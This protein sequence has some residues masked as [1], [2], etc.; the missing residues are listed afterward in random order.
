MEETRIK[1]FARV[2]PCK[3]RK[4]E[5]AGIFVDQLDEHQLR[6]ELDSG[7]TQPEKNLAYKYD[8]IFWKDCT[9]EEIYAGTARQMIETSVKGINTTIFAYGQTGAGKTYTMSGSRDNQGIIPRA[10]HDVFEMLPPGSKVEVSCMEIYMERVLDLIGSTEQN[11][12]RVIIRETPNGTSCKNLSKVPASTPEEAYNIFIAA[13]KHRKVATTVLNTV[14][15]RSHSI[16]T[17][18]LEIPSPEGPLVSQMNFV[19]LAGSERIY[20]TTNYQKEQLDEGKCINYSLLV[21]TNVIKALSTHMSHIPYRESKL[22]HFLKSSLSGNCKTFM[23]TNLSSDRQHIDETLNSCTFAVQ[24]SSVKTKIKQTMKNRTPAEE[25][26]QLRQEIV[27]LKSEEPSELP[28]GDEIT[29]EREQEL[30]DMVRRF[31]GSEIEAL[32]VSTSKDI[33]FCMEYLK[34]II[35]DGNDA[36]IRLSFLKKRIT[37][38]ES[39]RSVYVKLLTS[40]NRG[41]KDPK[42]KA[43]LEFSNTHESGVKANRLKQEIQMAVQRGEE[44][45]TQINRLAQEYEE[46]AAQQDEE[47]DSTDSS[48]YAGRLQE[49]VEEYNKLVAAQEECEEEVISLRQELG[50]ARMELQNAFQEF[51]E[52]IIMA[53]PQKTK[54][55][56]TKAATLNRS[57]H[58]PR[59]AR[60]RH[61]PPIV[62][63]E[64]P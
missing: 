36:V 35:K 57:I 6:F 15:S 40:G 58:M 27:R 21:L 28:E 17:I 55:N 56:K 14:S 63:K 39:Q 44:Y 34:G 54:K 18:Y 22:T 12:V 19:D 30:M 51:W 64:S 37:T 16:F 48:P 45:S 20:A 33:N 25:I 29:P 60:E 1:V 59:S 2:R 24:I 5:Y 53:Y 3:D 42:E 41:G 8:K 31:V 62:T 61:L 46:L 11:F 50:A 13:E 23:I 7:F 43:F 10:I 38:L 47:E 9:Q 32:D 49:I 26:A 52:S 4:Q